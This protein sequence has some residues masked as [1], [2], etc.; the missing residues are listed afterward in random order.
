MK[1]II[2]DGEKEQKRFVSSGS[3]AKITTFQA[4]NENM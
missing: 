1:G 3:T 4:D 2:N